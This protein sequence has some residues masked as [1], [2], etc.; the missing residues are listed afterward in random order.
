VNTD[1]VEPIDHRAGAVVLDR[2]AEP[3]QG[4][5]PRQPRAIVRAEAASE[6]DHP[7]P[8]QRESLRRPRIER[9]RL[10]DLRRWQPTLRRHLAEQFRELPVALIPPG[11]AVAKVGCKP[12]IATGGAEEAAGE[13]HPHRLQRPKVQV[14]AAAV[15]GRQGAG[16]Q[17]RRGEGQRGDR[18]VEEAR[19]HHPPE[20]VAAT[21]PAGSP[22]R[23]ATGQHHLAA[24]LAQLLRELRTR[25]ATA[26][27]QHVARRQRLGVPVVADVGLRQVGRERLGSRWPSRALEGAGGDHHQL[28]AQLA[29]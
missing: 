19:R 13:G 25:L 3:I 29:R 8:S 24:R 26:H 5:R 14:V 20:D 27:H 2:E 17:P 22:R 12:C 10:W 23:P 4:V 16:G 18:R 7:E 1:E 21:D 15:A 28:G 9:F 6:D 11:H